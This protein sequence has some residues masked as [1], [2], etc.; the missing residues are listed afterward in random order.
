MSKLKT[1]FSLFI[2][3]LK[4][5]LLTF[6]GGY[7]MIAVIEREITEKK[8]W[9]SSEEFLDVIAI[10]ESTPG[11][12]AINTSTFVGYKKCGVL[13]AI[14][15]TLGVVLPSFTII[16]LIS[17]FFDS[18]L[19]LK[20]V[21]YAFKGIQVAVAFLIITAGI[22]MFSHLKRTVFNIVLFSLSVI[23]LLLLTLFAVK[24]STIYFIL[25]GGFIG[26]IFY[27]I[28]FYAA[29]N[30]KN[31]EKKQENSLNSGEEEK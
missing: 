16:F 22:R 13:G 18:F 4:V 8:K 12:L 1:I 10:A 19:E 3:M 5:G 27:L 20:F 14:F 7:A 24:F 31:V 17:L 26:V 29:K 15:S 9:L 30:K 6:G 2:T 23:A 21:E 25:I 28:Q 11:P